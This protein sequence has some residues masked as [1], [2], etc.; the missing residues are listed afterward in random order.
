MLQKKSKR[1][2]RLSKIET[3]W[4]VMPGGEKVEPNVF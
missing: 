3:D 2:G 1:Q 4:P